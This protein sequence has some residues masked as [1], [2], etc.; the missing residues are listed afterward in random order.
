MKSRNNILLVFC[1]IGLAVLDLSYSLGETETVKQIVKPIP[2]SDVI[3]Q[4]KGNVVV[5]LLGME[6]CP[7]T[8][9]ATTFLADFSK[10]KPEGVRIC[11]VDVP[12]PGRKVEKAGNVSSALEYL[13]DNDRTLARRLEFFFYPTLYIMDRDGVVRFSGGCD[14]DKVRMMATELASEPAGAEKKMYTPPL[15]RVGEIIPDFNIGDIN[16]KE[17]SLGKLCGQDGAILF[18]GSTYCPFSLDATADLERLKKDFADRKL[19]Y[20]VVSFGQTADKVREV[21]ARE[22]PGSVVVID[23]DKSVSGRQFG[24]SAVPFFYLL[25]KNR[26]VL[27]RCPFVYDSVK[28]AIVKAQGKANGTGCGPA[29]V[30]AG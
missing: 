10:T 5:A 26:K 20:V 23:A 7:G 18:F 22:T 29:A 16:G 24:V 17:V 9:T 25:D 4:N 3:M 2:A 8:E 28:S 21:Y 15:V 14:P 30:G 1:M 11:R 13:V 12:L 27:D 19:S 6:G